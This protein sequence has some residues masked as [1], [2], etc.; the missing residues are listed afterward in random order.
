MKSSNICNKDPK[1]SVLVPVYGAEKWIARCARSLFEQT[2]EDVEFIFVNDCTKD[3][4][5]EVLR[6]VAK[7]YTAR[8]IR[9]IEHE[10][11]A[12]VSVARQTA[13]D[14]ARGEYW[15]F[16]DSDDFVDNDFCEKLYNAAKNTGADIACC[17][18]R[19]EFWNGSQDLTYPYKVETLQQSL[20][21]F[22]IDTLLGSLCNKLVNARIYRE[23][24]I[25]QWEFVKLWEDFL[26][27]LRVSAF[28]NF[29]VIVPDVYYHYV[30]NNGTSLTH[31]FNSNLKGCSA[32]ITADK[33]LSILQGR[34]KG[35]A[36]LERFYKENGLEN[37]ASEMVDYLKVRSRMPLLLVA[38]KEAVQCFKQNFKESNSYIWRVPDITIAEKIVTQAVVVL[39]T[40][41]CVP[42]L[43]MARKISKR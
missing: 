20:H 32:R 27:V 40:C 2:L 43:K 11:N 1:V 28:A 12:G 31:V 36:C 35:V 41:V 17:N 34:I 15:I 26:M 21:N 30:R 37:E 4:S 33:I 16:C 13:M 38:T 8:D 25:R 23:H 22:V 18:I 10:K 9:I 5:I 29:K 7:D 39:P 14:N 3:K 24:N 42:L 6:S 19:K